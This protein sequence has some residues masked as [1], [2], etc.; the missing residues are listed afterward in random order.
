MGGTR[1]KGGPKRGNQLE[2]RLAKMVGVRPYA[3][4]LQRSKSEPEGAMAARGMTVLGSAVGQLSCKRKF[5]GADE[6][7]IPTQ[8][9]IV[10]EWGAPAQA[11]MEPCFCGH[12]IR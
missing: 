12:C 1:V 8:Q 6:R 10:A 7:K 3:S 2:A 11:Q 9:C 5:A 4:G